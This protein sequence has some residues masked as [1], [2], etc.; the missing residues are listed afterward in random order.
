MGTHQPNKQP[1]KGVVP[2]GEPI[3]NY[4]PAVVTEQE[5]HAA[6]AALQAHGGDFDVSGKFRRGGKGVRGAGRKGIGEPNL[7]PG[8]LHCALTGERLNIV[9]AF[10]RKGDG[11]RLRY[12]YL[13]PTLKSGKCHGLRLNYA[14]FAGAILSAL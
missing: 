8:L 1:G 7:F 4:Y 13:M 5:W 11:E 6:Q 3:P 12:R 9:H 10:G 14:V 2:D